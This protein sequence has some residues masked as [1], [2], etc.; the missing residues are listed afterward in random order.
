MIAA[1]PSTAL[2]NGG[3]VG[4][5]SSKHEYYVVFPAGA[6]GLELEPVIKSSE[7]EIGCRVKDFYYGVDYNGIEPR[8]LE[9]LVAIGDIICSL[10]DVNVRSMPF[11][12]IVDMIRSKRHC[13]RRVLFK[14]MAFSCKTFR[15][16]SYDNG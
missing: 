4:S 15:C 16:F 14:N 10:D 7:R 12:E 8:R 2:G 6:M 11:P 13:Q 1:K 3:F 5:S 9:G